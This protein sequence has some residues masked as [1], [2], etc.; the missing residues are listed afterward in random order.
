[1][2][3][4]ESALRQWVKQAQIDASGEGQGQLSGWVSLNRE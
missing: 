3:L 1:M 2:G 4:T